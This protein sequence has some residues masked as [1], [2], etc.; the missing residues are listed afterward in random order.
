MERE[1]SFIFASFH[2]PLY[3]FFLESL[4]LLSTP[5]FACVGFVVPLRVSSS[6]S[7]TN[8]EERRICFF[9]FA[10]VLGERE[11]A[12]LLVVYLSASLSISSVCDSIRDSSGDKR[13]RERDPF[14]LK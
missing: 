5:C 1:V 13:E 4:L 2:F 3:I 14:S 9:S 11:R 12:R 8:E 10:C 7:N 6:S